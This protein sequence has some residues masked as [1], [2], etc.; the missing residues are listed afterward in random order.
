METRS[1]IIM[2]GLSNEVVGVKRQSVVSLH[3]PSPNILLT[4]GQILR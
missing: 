4:P 1:F 2:S 3:H